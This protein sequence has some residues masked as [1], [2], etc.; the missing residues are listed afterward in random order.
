MKLFYLRHFTEPLSVMTM[1][2][3]LGQSNLEEAAKILTDLEANPFCLVLLA[4]IQAL[5]VSR[6]CE[7]QVVN[8]ASAKGKEPASTE[9]VSTKNSEDE[10]L[11]R[12]PSRPL[13]KSNKESKSGSIPLDPSSLLSALRALDDASEDHRNRMRALRIAFR[14][15]YTIRKHLFK[16]GIIHP[17]RIK[18]QS[19]KG[20]E[21]EEETIG[22]MCAC[23]KGRLNAKEC[24]RLIEGV[25]CV[26]FFFHP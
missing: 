16:A 20:G 14:L 23:L 26:L 2:S 1:N 21:E 5:N 3:L 13:G 9:D 25:W 22:L 10:I 11:I 6:E 17:A 19:Q 4:R 18:N 24:R 7:A 8:G 12:S 15:V